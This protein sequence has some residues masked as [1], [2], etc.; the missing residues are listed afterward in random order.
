M[1][2]CD[3]TKGTYWLGLRPMAEFLRMTSIS[4]RTST[5]S[6]SSS[7][8]SLLTSTSWDK[9]RIMNYSLAAPV[10]F[11][12]TQQTSLLTSFLSCFSKSIILSRKLVDR[13]IL[14]AYWS[15]A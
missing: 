8:Y 13:S 5:A 9:M 15:F 2:L 10:I 14:I 11:A 6:P 4:L 7:S 1:V 12:N 3:L